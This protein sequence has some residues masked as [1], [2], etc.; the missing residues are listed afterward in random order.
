VQETER[1]NQMKDVLEEIDEILSCHEEDSDK[2]ETESADINCP[3]YPRSIFIEFPIDCA[4]YP[5]SSGLIVSIRDILGF[6][7]DQ[8]PDIENIDT[9]K[10]IREMYYGGD[11]TDDHED[12]HL[13]GYHA[14]FDSEA[15][16][17]VKWRLDQEHENRE[18]RKAEIDE[19]LNSAHVIM[20]MPWPTTLEGAHDEYWIRRERLDG[21]WYDFVARYEAAR[22][23][24]QDLGSF[25]AEREELR[26]M[27]NELEE[28]LSNLLD[29]KYRLLNGG[30]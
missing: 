17:R 10:L 2:C 28:E 8:R 9:V 20:E 12:P 30:E 6:V 23:R 27:N 14:L 11:Y 26:T 21:L 15:R 24:S 19:E 29:M 22:N 5:G 3:P 4:T 13:S 7:I 1:E 25:D 18:R 16:A